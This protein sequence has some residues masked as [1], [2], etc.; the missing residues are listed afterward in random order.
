M[1][2]NPTEQTKLGPGYDVYGVETETNALYPN[3]QEM[4]D[5]ASSPALLV[6]EVVPE[7]DVP[8]LGL[9]P[10]DPLTAENLREVTGPRVTLARNPGDAESVSTENVI[11]G[12]NVAEP[13][14]S[15]SQMFGDAQHHTET[16][17]TSGQARAK[18]PVGRVRHELSPRTRTADLRARMARV[19]QT[20]MTRYLQAPPPPPPS[21]IVPHDTVTRAEADMAL[22]ELQR[23]IGDANQRTD[24]LVQAVSETR[25]KA[26]AAGQ[27]A[28]SGATG[29]AQTN[30]GLDQ[31][32]QE[33]RQ[34]LQNMRTKIQGAEQRADAAQR[35]ADVAE[36]RADAA[37]HAA[38][39]AEQRAVAA[40]SNADAAQAKQ[41][42]LEQDL[43]NADVAFQEERKIRTKEIAAAQLTIGTLRR[44]L[45][46][47]S[48]RLDQ[49]GAIVQNVAGIGGELREARKDMA[50][51]AAEMRQMGDVTDEVLGH[52]EELTTAFHQI[53]AE[54]KKGNI[55]NPNDVK[56]TP[57]HVQ[58]T[59]SDVKEPA[60]HVQTEPSSVID[61]MSGD[62][63]E[64]DRQPMTGRDYIKNLV[65]EQYR[66]VKEEIRSGKQPATASAPKST[67]AASSTPQMTSAGASSS[68]GQRLSYEPNPQ[69]M[70]SS[71][72]AEQSGEKAAPTLFGIQGEIIPPYDQRNAANDGANR[73]TMLQKPEEPR[74]IV[75]S[76]PRLPSGT[77]RAIEKIVQAHM[78]QLGINVRSQQAN[79]DMRESMA[80]NNPNPEPETTQFA[81]PDLRS[82]AANAGRQRQVFATAQWRP[83]EPPMFTGNASDDVYLWT[84]LVQQYLV[85]MEGTA[86][87]EVA[88]AATLLRGAAHEWYR[89]YEKRNG[90]QPPQDWPTMQQAILERFGSN[91]RAQEAHAKLLTISQGKRSVRDY[92][93]EFETLLGRLSTRDEATWKNMYMWG[94]QPHLAEAVALKYPN[95]IAQA[96]GHAEEI[97][98]AKK[99]S[100]RPNL[101]GQGARPTG[102]FSGRGGSQSAPRVFTQGRGRGNVGT[103]QREDEELEDVVVA[104]GT[105]DV[106]EEARPLRPELAHSVLTV[107]SMDIMLHNVQEMQVH[108]AAVVL[109]NL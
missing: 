35:V 58:G 27:I 99:A 29:V 1:S 15:G 88:F 100:H 30:A 40:Q 5:T 28:V 89:G 23:Q 92:T 11:A 79:E 36:Q 13:T 72:M 12:A 98:L 20:R 81:F 56:S 53:D 63:E 64:E 84:S 66:K 96:A 9:T 69:V 43:R 93:S 70:T 103:Y 33:L 104:D 51:Q 14:A 106:K 109:H 82:T 6:G 34:E 21:A 71:Q 31:M 74:V 75:N 7:S 67:A 65:D 26:Q 101:G 2:H 78:E 45:H 91:I 17:A 22:G 3:D 54:Q 47:A 46:D 57:V 105:A 102:Q 86:R 76:P 107:V 50:L 18:S 41:E 59:I 55:V 25:Q 61:L 48:T 83:K 62:Y 68:F 32:L 19:R 73:P 80:G 37:Q 87:Q 38:D 8:S 60:G 52:V 95:T 97:E 39:M 44:E 85:F 42:R 24:A 10:T 16:A 94:L 49:Q 108:P 90:N 77:Q 4:E